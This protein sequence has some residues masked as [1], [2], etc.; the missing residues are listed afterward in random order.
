MQ[1]VRAVRIVAPGVQ[2]LGDQSL[3]G[4]SIDLGG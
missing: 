1:R 2:M 3:E 4:K